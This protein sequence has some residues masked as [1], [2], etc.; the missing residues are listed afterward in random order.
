MA[1][2]E[3]VDHPELDRKRKPKADGAKGGKAGEEGQ[4]AA[5]GPKDPFG[6]FRKMF[7]GKSKVNKTGAGKAA[8]SAKGGAARKTPAAGG[9]GSKTGGSSG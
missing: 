3:L 9:G 8:K 6:G 4:V 5:A 7:A 2:L 1:V